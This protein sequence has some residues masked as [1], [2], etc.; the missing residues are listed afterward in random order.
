MFEI[1]IDGKVKQFPERLTTKQWMRLARWDVSHHENWPFII[2]A[3]LE[4]HPKD[5]EEM[6]EGQ[7]ELIVGFT[8][9]LMNR[10]HQSPGFDLSQLTFG[11]WVDLDVWTAEG[12]DKSLLK[13][14][15]NLRRY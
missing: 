1:K 7:Q 12:F 8:V 13:C 3:M 9:S 15:N 6:P 11:E 5:V 14:L 2:G 10:R 4:I